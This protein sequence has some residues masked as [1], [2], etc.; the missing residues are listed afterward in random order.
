MYAYTLYKNY[1]FIV[2]LLYVPYSYAV[3]LANIMFG[4][5]LECNANW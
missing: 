4:G 2:N 1:V 5:E 3:H